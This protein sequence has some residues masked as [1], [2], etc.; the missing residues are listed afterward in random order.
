MQR[1]KGSEMNR[2]GGT[3]QVNQ[4]TARRSSFYKL[5]IYFWKMKINLYLFY[6]YIVAI[7]WQQCK[8]VMQQCK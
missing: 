4:A 2:T 6:V 7:N 8:T 5:F 1:Y 3:A